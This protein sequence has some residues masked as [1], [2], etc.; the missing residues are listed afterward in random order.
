M[1]RWWHASAISHM[2]G[3]HGYVICRLSIVLYFASGDGSCERK[4]NVPNMQVSVLQ[5]LRRRR[6]S[7][8]FSG[9]RKKVRAFFQDHTHR[10]RRRSFK[11]TSRSSAV[12]IG[13]LWM[14]FSQTSYHERRRDGPETQLR[15]EQQVTAHSWL[16]RLVLRN[17][18]W[19]QMEF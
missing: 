2:L 7:E 5:L 11:W 8:L 6:A 1:Q 13:D 4:F 10:H 9:R 17:F 15:V 18:R 12:A 14:T 3:V 19:P 16:A